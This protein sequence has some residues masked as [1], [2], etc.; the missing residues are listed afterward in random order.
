MVPRRSSGQP[1]N[2]IRSSVMKHTQYAGTD[3]AHGKAET[4]RTA[5][6]RVRRENKNLDHTAGTGSY[7]SW[8][9]IY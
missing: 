6:E 1:E 2:L 7:Q 5:G 9:R 8:G 3:A 4:G